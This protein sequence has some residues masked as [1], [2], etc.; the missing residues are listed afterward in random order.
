MEKVTEY[1]LDYNQDNDSEEFAET[2]RKEA[3][4]F[5]I[6]WRWEIIDRFVNKNAYN[7][8]KADSV[9]QSSSLNSK[10][11]GKPMN[12]QKKELTPEQQKRISDLMRKHLEENLSAKGIVPKPSIPPSKS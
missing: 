3:H 11:R 2:I 6:A 1:D 10:Q 8:H 12:G 9:K 5:I 4:D 7:N